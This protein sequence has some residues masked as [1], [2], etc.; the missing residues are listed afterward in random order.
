MILLSPSS[1]AGL[2]H[3]QSCKVFK[4]P[5]DMIDFLTNVSGIYNKFS[6]API[7]YL[8]NENTGHIELCSDEWHRYYVYPYTFNTRKELS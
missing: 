4:N 7:A 2:I 3:I 1:R 6:I 8:L 5:T